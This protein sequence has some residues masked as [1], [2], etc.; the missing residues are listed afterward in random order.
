M[1]ELGNK[2]GKT[3]LIFNLKDKVVGKRKVGQEATV[4]KD[5]KTNEEVN[6][7]AGIKKVS[8]DYCQELLTNREP[9][10]EYVD[11]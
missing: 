5:P 4:L 7:P 1:K 6:T 8:I 11:D 10:D 2:K 3:A 9:K